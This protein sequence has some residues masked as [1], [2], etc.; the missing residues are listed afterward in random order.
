MQKSLQG[1]IRALQANPSSSGTF[2]LGDAKDSDLAL[3][4]LPARVGRSLERP[5]ANF[6][7]PSREAFL[8][9][10]AELIE[11][12]PL[13]LMVVSPRVAEE[14]AQRGVFRQCPVSPVIRSA[15]GHWLPQAAVA[16]GGPSFEGPIPLFGVGFC[17]DEAMDQA[18]LDA[19]ERFR[20]KAGAAHVRHLLELY[21]SCGC[22]GG[23]P[24]RV[25]DILADRLLHSLL[26]VPPV[27]RPMLVQAPYYGPRLMESLAESLPGMPVGIVGGP[28]GTTF[29]AFRLLAESKRYGARA[30]IFGRRISAAEHQPAFVRF[31][32]YLAKDD[33]RPEEAVHAYHGVLQGLGIR[34]FRELKEDLMPTADLFH[35]DESSTASVVVPDRPFDP[36]GVE[37][38]SAA[39]GK[40]ETPQWNRNRDGGSEPDFDAMTI[41]EKLEYNQRQRDRIFG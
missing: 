25:D 21:P 35:G 29:D 38:R 30:A 22:D 14:T 16:E 5:D 39:A 2:V 13:D 40:A 26:E 36:P 7:Y 41:E 31:L 33:V 3:R 34:P 17:R 6:P 27:A 24:Q 8:D 19:Y 4:G 28:A 37:F 12:G 11:S 1:K 18:E 10:I 23:E 15:Q 9:Q 32:D 20:L